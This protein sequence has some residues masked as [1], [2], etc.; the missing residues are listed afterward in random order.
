MQKTI[1]EPEAGIEFP[2]IS[3]LVTAYNRKE[4]ILEAV[5][6]VLNQ[7]LERSKYEIIVVKNYVDDNIDHLL[8]EYG[9]V[10][11]YTD[12]IALGAKLA[13]GMEKARGEILCFL[14][15]DDLFFPVKLEEVYTAFKENPRIVFLRNEVIKARSVRSEYNDDN[16]KYNLNDGLVLFR[17]QQIKTTAMIYHLVVKYGANVNISSMSV[18]KKLYFPYKIEMSDFKFLLDTFLFI[19][20]F[21]SKDNDDVLAFQMRSLSFW[22][23]HESFSNTKEN[24]TLS[25][26]I[27]N[28]LQNAS[29]SITGIKKMIAIREKYSNEENYEPIDQ[30]L[31][32]A[33]G[34]YW[35]GIKLIEGKRFEFY[36]VILLFKVG[37]YHKDFY[38]LA[39]SILGLVSIFSPYI[40]AKIF[41][42]A[43]RLQI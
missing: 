41:R 10:N 22:R 19:L 11:V 38:I 14:E 9:V 12:E 27:D 26:R 7:T 18:K 30:Y 4:Y 24:P 23:V 5:K 29:R 25:E 20:P 16:S 3:V 39:S 43:L 15:D 35:T 13:Y 2:L 32:L 28:H 1:S 37:Y 42:N 33:R 40:S 8:S 36:E 21:F 6:S 31:E 17:M 34:A